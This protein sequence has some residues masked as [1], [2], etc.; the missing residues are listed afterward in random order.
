MDLLY[1]LPPTVFLLLALI[2][3]VSLA[4]SVQYFVHRRFDGKAFVAHNEVGGIIVV[5][6]SALYAVLLGFMTVVASEHVQ[7]SREIVVVESDA[8]IDAW[9]TAVGL[10]ET[11]R[12]R[13]RTDMT[14]YVQIMTDREWLLM[15]SGKSDYEAAMVGMDALDATGGFSPTTLGQSNAQAATLQQLDALH[16]AR[17]RRIGS[18][19]AGLTGFEW[20]VLDLGAMSII[21]FCW[22]FGGSRPRVQMIMTATVV[23]MIISTLTLLFELQYPFRSIIGVGPQAW[24]AAQEHIHEMESGPM[25]DMRK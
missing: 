16:D 12:Q 14:R 25:P 8:S 20:L 21:S 9:H 23:I 15:R 2:A 4:L 1:R 5:V 22:L 11:V 18:N 6:I 24:Q 19:E 10:P 13:V 17:Q 7:E 3:S